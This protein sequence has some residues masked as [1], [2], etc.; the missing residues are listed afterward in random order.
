MP[1]IAFD[2]SLFSILLIPMLG[3]VGLAAASGVLG[4]FIVWRRMAYFGDTLA[5]A[6]LLGVSLGTVFS[7]SPTLGV[8][9]VCLIIATTLALLQ[10]QKTLADDTLLGIMSH[11][12]L[13]LGLI[14]L[15]VHPIQGKSLHNLL[16]GDL[17]TLTWGNVFT[18]FGYSA[19][20]L[21]LITSYWRSLTSWVID[22]DL[23]QVEGHPVHALRFGL[24]LAIAF[25]IALSMQFVGVLL[26]TA[27][28]ITPAASARLLAKSPEHMAVLSAIYAI[29]A[30]ILGTTAAGMFD[31]PL[32]PSIV[33]AT[34]LGFTLTFLAHQKRAS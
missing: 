12:A 4:C 2:F 18:I 33:L 14:V 26:I 10:K 29:I 13:S 28:L 7:L 27:L 9:G 34:T 25:F 11:G 20:L 3:G 17:V 21:L 19:V 32:G 31:W 24:M 8:L 1:D 22:E 6:S 15:A 16:L 23:A 30:T 5:H